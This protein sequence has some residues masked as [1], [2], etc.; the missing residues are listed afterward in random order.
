MPNAVATQYVT[1]PWSRSTANRREKTTHAAIS[2]SIA[3]PNPT[4]CTML[5][6]L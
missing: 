5:C 6:Q 3:R 2:D 1:Q 4:P